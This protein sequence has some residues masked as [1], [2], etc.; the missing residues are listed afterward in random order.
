MRLEPGLLALAGPVF[1][2]MRPFEEAPCTASRRRFER[3][4]QR[5]HLARGLILPSRI[6]SAPYHLVQAL[7]VMWCAEELQA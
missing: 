4:P 2:L 1:D 7:W 3:W 5:N 6:F